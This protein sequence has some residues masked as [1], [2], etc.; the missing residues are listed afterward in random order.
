MVFV[1]GSLNVFAT[2]ID[3]YQS[4]DIFFY[5]EADISDYCKTASIVKPDTRIANYTKDDE[6]IKSIYEA[7][8]KP[9]TNDTSKAAFTPV[10]ASAIMGNMFAESSFIVGSEE[11]TVSPVK[12][13]GLAQWT[14]GR[15]TKLEN[16]ATEQGKP[17]NDLQLQINYLYKEYYSTYIK[18]LSNKID[19]RNPVFTDTTSTDIEL[20]TIDWVIK[21]EAPLMNSASDDPAALYSKRIPMAEKIYS[22]FVGG[23]TDSC[24]SSRGASG[25][26]NTAL[27]YAWPE[28]KVGDQRGVWRSRATEAYQRDF[29]EVYSE[30][31]KSSNDNNYVYWSDCGKFV[32]FVMIKSGVD[33]NYNPSRGNTYAHVDYIKQHS[34]LYD[35]VTSPGGGVPAKNQLKAGDIL[36]FRGASG[37]TIGHAAIYY[38]DNK[39]INASAGD[40]TPEIE[41]DVDWMLKEMGKKPDGDWV[42]GRI[43]Q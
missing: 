4:N 17:V 15:R 19:G 33:K 39:L 14:K 37:S 7:L 18:L 8:T 6:T 35:I 11:N 22:L 34:D 2:D 21:F 10:Q 26:I 3:F 23:S 24:N 5:N 13:Y 12:G 43:K 38:E 32:T 9:P 29:P 16:F 36:V 41:K 1:F 27:L 25:I 28:D 20:A 40:N 42:V 30:A 31:K